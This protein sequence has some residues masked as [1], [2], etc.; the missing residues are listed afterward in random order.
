MSWNSWVANTYKDEFCE[1]HLKDMLV[2]EK[3][4][5]LV[6]SAGVGSGFARD[7]FEEIAVHHNQE[8]FNTGSLT[9]DYEIGM[10]FRLA[11][12]R[13]Y[14]AVRS[15]KRS[16][17]VER[18][19][20]RKRKVRIIEDEYIAT[21]E[22]FPSDLRFAI[23]QRSRWVLGIA[24]QGWEQIGWKGSLPVLYCL[25]RDRKALIT[26]YMNIFAYAVVLYCLT[27]LTAG[28]VSGRPW[29]FDNIFAPGSVLWW[30][31][32]VNTLVLT[33]RALMKYLA[34]DR[35]FG[36]L[37]GLLTLPRF[38]VSNVINFMATS[39]ALRQYINHR[40]TGE[41]LRC[42]RRT[43]P[44]R[45]STSCVTTSDAWVSSSWTGRDSARIRS[46]R[47][48]SCRPR[49]CKL[50]EVFTMTGM[51]STG[52][53]RTPW[54]TSSPC[55]SWIDPTPCPGT[56]PGDP[57]A[58]AEL[59]GILPLEEKDGGVEMAISKAP[60]PD[61]RD[62]L[63]KLMNT[64]VRFVFVADG[65]LRRARERAYRRIITEPAGT[66]RPERLGQVLLNRGLLDERELHEALEEQGETGE[67]LGELLVR[68]GW[69]KESEISRI[70]SRRHSDGFRTVA[71]AEA[72]PKA[73]RIVGY[74]LCALYGMVPLN[75]EFGD[76]YL[77]LASSWP[78][79]DES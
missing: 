32:M 63:E 37:H 62:K 23:R 69:V 13:T 18:G 26:N 58:D 70:L 36:P 15:I 44:S 53:S 60:E 14:F 42:P 31:V 74:G 9:E 45:A 59:W 10:K 46:S 4:G 38:F 43:T 65:S 25:W 50:G 52:A 68:K 41:P 51:V 3:I 40:I 57:E 66:T 29:T 34:V 20:F 75:T 35:I 47:L 67:Q 2:R 56:A 48:S 76:G 11:N 64:T 21:R 12:K 24:M 22:F 7:A 49:R 54:R 17:I 61:L 6:P 77:A 5:G 1:H 78:V 33:W 79:H 8:V 30:M 73:L 16:R 19:I 72:D 39:K 55:R 27:R 28:W 71:A